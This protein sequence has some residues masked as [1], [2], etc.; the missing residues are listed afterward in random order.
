MHSLPVFVRLAGRPVI[1]IG[2][3]EAAE[4]KRRL[5]ERAGAVVVGEE[6]EAAGGFAPDRLQVLA[7][8]GQAEV[9][10]PVALRR[11]AHRSSR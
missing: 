1:L 7:H 10:H 8:P 3:G 9:V 5:L 6:A 11:R 2:T 4:A